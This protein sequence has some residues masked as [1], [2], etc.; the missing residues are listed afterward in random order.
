MIRCR[1]ASPSSD[2][3]IACIVGSITTSPSAEFS[4][5]SW[6]VTASNPCSARDELPIGARA[7]K[8][9]EPDMVISAHASARSPAPG[10]HT[11]ARGADR[12]R[13]AIQPRSDRWPLTPSGC[14]EF[15][16]A[17]QL[18]TEFRDEEALDY[19]ELASGRATDP[20]VRAS[21]AAFVAGLLLGSH[22][23]WEV[24]AWAEIVR[25]NA[26]RPDLGDFLDAAARLQLDDI[27]GARAGARAG[28][29][30]DRPLV[31]VLGHRGPD[32]ACARGVSRRRRRG[33]PR[34]S[35][36]DVRDRSLRARGMGRVRAAVRRERF[37]SRPK[38]SRQVPDDRT[39]EV[40]TALRSSAPEGVDRI[41][42]LIWNRNPGD[43][44][45]LALVPRFASK[46]ESVRAMEW[47]ARMRGVGM[48]RTCP[49]LARAEDER[50]EPIERVRACALAHAAFGD[51]R[52]RELL[53]KAA[54]DLDDDE[55]VEAVVEVW[56]IAAALADSVVA[57]AATTPTR[58]L[59][60]TTSLFE[61][62]AAA[63]GLRGARARA[64]A[65]SRGVV[66]DRRGRAAPAGAGARRPRGR[67]RGARR[68]RTWPGFS[69][70]CWSW[71]AN[72]DREDR[73]PRR[74]ARE[75]VLRDRG[76]GRQPRP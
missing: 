9:S 20:A 7:A 55:V 37:R 10:V 28:R 60:I 4:H 3:W 16:R 43:A 45:V 71:P 23:P 15:D 69:K 36:R 57:S 22:R 34:R 62:G 27:E 46:L 56:T 72:G 25:E 38:W 73:P 1:A 53:E 40:I 30:P 19:F 13:T 76:S 74:R 67:S 33:R 47:S 6:W 75:P 51:R 61:R 49:L 18:L 21:A 39:F 54:P 70:R 17:R 42:E 24:D 63:R 31:P 2:V 66:D 5:P 12:G 68:T 32:R 52:A 26:A 8:L 50:V 29:G 59:A 48:G 58:S 44:R 41:A 14:E 64:L 11:S 35:A 65:R